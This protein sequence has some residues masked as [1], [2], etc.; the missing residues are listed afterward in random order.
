MTPGAYDHTSPTRGNYLLFRA[1]RRRVDP[2]LRKMPRVGHDHQ[3][4]TIILRFHL[5]LERSRRNLKLTT[6]NRV[7]HEMLAIS[8]PN[9]VR[10]FSPFRNSPSGPNRDR[11]ESRNIPVSMVGRYIFVGATGYRLRRQQ[12][13]L[14]LSFRLR[15]STALR[16]RSARIQCSDE[17]FVS[18]SPED[19]L[20]ACGTNPP[21]AF[22][23][24]HSSHLNQ[25]SASDQQGF[26]PCGKP[27]HRRLLHLPGPTHPLIPFVPAV[28]DHL[29]K[30]RGPCQSRAASQ[31]VQK[32]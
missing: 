24:H 6:P 21:C 5:R 29:E 19:F 25:W 11:R 27:R 10:L 18:R 20:Q 2:N 28:A 14:R 23:R 12:H 15:I 32:Q 8:H 22:H 30:A 26:R 16:E 1:I 31:L 3:R 4:R 17:L 13:L 7:H 9:L